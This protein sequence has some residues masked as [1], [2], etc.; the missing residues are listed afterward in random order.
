MEE[1]NAT[2]DEVVVDKSVKEFERIAAL[3]LVQQKI[4][5]EHQALNIAW[6]SLLV[7]VSPKIEDM[8]LWGVLVGL[9]LLSMFYS[10]F[11]IGRLN[12]FRT[13]I[14]NTKQET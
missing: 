10:K 1:N 4:I 9:I 5:T 13:A 8:F 6:L 14:L 11:V 7:V 12:A 2:N 3:H